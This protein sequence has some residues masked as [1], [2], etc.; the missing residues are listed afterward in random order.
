[1]NDTTGQDKGK[2]LVFPEGKTTFEKMVN[3]LINRYY[4]EGEQHLMKSSMEKAFED[5]DDTEISGLDECFF[6]LQRCGHRAVA[7]NNI[8]G[9]C[10]VLHMISD[11]LLSD[12]LLQ[13]TALLN[14]AITKMSVAVTDHTRKGL[15]AQ[16]DTS[17]TVSDGSVDIT[18]VLKGATSLASSITGQ[19][20]DVDG[21]NVV[22]GDEGGMHGLTA[23]IENFNTVEIC[24]KYTER[25]RREV[26]C[27]SDQV[28]TALDEE[29][30]KMK[31]CLQDF[32][33]V[34]TA[35]GQVLR[36]GSEQLVNALQAP[37]KEVISFY[38]G[39]NGLMGGIKLELDDEHFDLQPAVGMLPKALVTPI[40]QMIDISTSNM[41]D[42]N[43]D[44]I[45]GLMANACCE[46][47]EQFIYQSTF[48][49]AGALKLE[50]CFRALSNMFTRYSTTPIRGKFSRLRE[51][52]QVLTAD[53]SAGVG[54]IAVDT[55]SHLTASE[56]NAFIALRVDAP[57]DVM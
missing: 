27:A 1:M 49:F 23:Y 52:C 13:V 8:N 41:S 3:E 40:E 7:T 56:V 33:S 2:I 42:G 39:R 17:Q 20:T 38:L 35:Y 37:L 57:T 45:V 26:Q 36:T 55:Y 18:S 11:L 34:K 31:L 24:S 48:G 15:I 54:S 14:M 16:G 4:M 43:K 5:R 30:D 9:A 19:Q 53:V 47:I 6:V 44:L 51:I 22:V 46:K 12:L 29:M 32:E 10:G 25:L 21:N 28:F 50:E